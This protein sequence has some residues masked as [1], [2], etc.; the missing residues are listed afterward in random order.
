MT[1]KVISIDLTKCKRR[2]S[3]APRQEQRPAKIV[4]TYFDETDIEATA[5]L[6][7]NVVRAA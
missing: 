7:R 2:Y 6:E 4:V 3:R 1:D 5:A